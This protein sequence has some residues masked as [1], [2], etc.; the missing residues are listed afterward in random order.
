MNIQL[1]A[2]LQFPGRLWK[3]RELW[4]RLTQREIL[5]RYRGSIL[6]IGWSLATPLAM[7]SIYTFVFSQVFKARWGGIENEGTLVFAVNLFAGLIVFNLFSECISR[8]PYLITSNSNYVKKVV[9]P[10]E[11]LAC[12][13]LGS[14]VFNAGVSLAVMTAF[15]IIAFGRLAPSI[16]WI[17]VIWIPLILFTLS[18]SWLL[19]AAGVFLRDVGQ[20]VI[21]SM[22]MLMFISP[23]FFPITALPP[24]WQPL[25]RLN[26]LA[27]LIEQTRQVAI[28]GLSP[29]P[30]YIVFGI[31]AS[32]LACELSFRTFQKAK[33]GFADVI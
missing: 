5:S 18:L 30:A 20:I 14:A 19:A 33:T 4:W 8:S 26:P 17:P 2:G 15:Q 10:L 16:I 11:V 9:F 3:H 23:I 12:S 21:V 28:E 22:N 31:I 24:N 29:S 32:T 7:L 25:L 1:K 6:G 13:S 27:L